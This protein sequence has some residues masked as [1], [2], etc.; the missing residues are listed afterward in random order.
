MESYRNLVDIFFSN[1]DFALKSGSKYRSGAWHQSE[2]QRDILLNKIKQ[3]KEENKAVTTIVAPLKEFYVAEEYHQ[4]YKQKFRLKIAKVHR[5][6]SAS[7]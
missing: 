5:T 7:V 3:L 4:K 6:Q 2:E 1:H